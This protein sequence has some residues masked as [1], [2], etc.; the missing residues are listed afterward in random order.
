MRILGRSSLAG[1]IAVGALGFGLV[2]AQACT[3]LAQLN[4][5]PPAGPG[6]TQIN[7]TGSSFSSVASG[8]QV[9]AIHLNSPTG[10]VL[11]SVTPD[12]SGSIGPVTVTI[13][14]GLTPGYY[15][16]VATQTDNTG[17]T[18][19]GTP[20]RAAFQVTGN[21]AAAPAP[22]QPAQ[23]VP[24]ASTSSSGLGTGA[25]VLLVVLGV[26]G[27]LVFGL[28]AATFVRGARKVPSASRV[29]KE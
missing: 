22:A 3:S 17:A 6:G 27:L 13:P 11:A 12:S 7:V 18:E 20:A 24:V 29:R 9:V 2:T 1:L 15:T 14:S 4:L 23:S 16:I 10:P 26:G 21:S 25:I 28:G 19:F 5:G 8:G